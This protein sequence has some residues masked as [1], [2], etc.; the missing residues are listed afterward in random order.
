[1]TSPLI[2]RAT[3]Q[4]IHYT[5]R[6]DGI[7]LELTRDAGTPESF[8]GKRLLARHFLQ[9]PV[10]QERVRQQFGDATAQQIYQALAQAQAALEKSLSADPSVDQPASKPNRD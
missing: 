8:G 2:W 9:K 6:I 4:G 7:H 5:A 3:V 10:W 1:M